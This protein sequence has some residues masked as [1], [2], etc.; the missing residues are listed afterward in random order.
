MMCSP[1]LEDSNS[2]R[3]V[4]DAEDERLFY[5]PNWL[6][7]CKSGD[8]LTALN[9]TPS[10]GCSLYAFLGVKKL[11]KI[12]VTREMLYSHKNSMNQ[13]TPNSI[14]VNSLPPVS[15]HQILS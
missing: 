9:S 10:L 3:I 15:L 1:I 6:I 12:Y 7:G 13:K 5:N 4:Y 14:K 8:Q 11:C 2:D